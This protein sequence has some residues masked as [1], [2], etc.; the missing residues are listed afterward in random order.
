MIKTKTRTVTALL[1][2]GLTISTI[3]LFIPAVSGADGW[4]LIYDARSM[5]AYSD[6]KEYVWQKN[7]SAPPHTEYDK[8][9]LHRLVK[10]G[11]ATKGVVFLIPNFANGGDE[12]ISNPPTD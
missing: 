12:Y 4:A 8:I 2:I 3:P 7:A 1:I 10:T 5:K 11:A 9:G 6:L